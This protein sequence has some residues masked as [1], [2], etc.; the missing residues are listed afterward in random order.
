MKLMLATVVAPR[1]LVQVALEPLRGDMAICA[2]DAALHQR[3]E[4]FDGVRVNVARHVDAS[5]VVDRFVGVARLGETVVQPCLVG[6]NDRGGFDV[7]GD[8]AHDRGPW[9]VR[10]D[11]RHNAATTLDHAKN[12]RLVVSPPCLSGLTALGR[13]GQTVP[14][15]T[16][17]LVGLPAN[18]RLIDFNSAAQ[19]AITIFDHEFVADLRKHPPGRLIRNA[20]LPFELLGRDAHSG[21]SHQEDGVE[22]QVQGRRGLVHDRVGG[23]VNVVAARVARVGRATRHAVELADLFAF[24]ALS[25]LTIGHLVVA[26][27]QVVEARGVVGELTHE[28]HDCVGRIADLGLLGVVAIRWGHTNNLP[29]G[30]TYCQGISAAHSELPSTPFVLFGVSP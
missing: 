3:P 13:G 7:G 25:V 21:R 11:A 6:V 4:A 8:L 27:P 29:R 17:G 22:P 20:Q 14:L 16:V 1:V 24:R 18:V 10:N 23:R 9:A 2:E 26:A 28:V 19:R 12:G 30:D 5:R 15:R